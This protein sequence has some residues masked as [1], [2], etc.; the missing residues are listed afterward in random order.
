MET[1]T[2]LI[3][4]PYNV[5]VDQAV[6]NL[7]RKVSA[8]MTYAQEGDGETGPLL[9]IR[10]LHSPDRFDQEGASIRRTIAS[11]NGQPDANSTGQTEVSE[12]ID[13]LD[14][15]ERIRA[16]RKLTRRSD[17]KV[18]GRLASVIGE[19]HDATIRAMAAIGLGK[20]RVDEAKEALIVALSDENGLVRRRA[21]Q[22]LGRMWGRDA[23]EPL[24]A[25][26]LEDADPANRREAALRLGQM[27]IEETFEI[28]S[29]A[30]SDTDPSVRR[31]VEHA[32]SALGSF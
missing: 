9:R 32:I 7:L 21:V 10:V 4:A 1:G 15:E 22:G 2:D 24:S 26:L 6:R 14:R 5:P 30:Q 18:V 3:S 29:Q 27:R 11:T 17:A 31:A 12:T 16:V 13:H 28:L 25:V 19:D 8:V 20:V 23:I